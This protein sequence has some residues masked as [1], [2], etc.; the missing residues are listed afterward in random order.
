MQTKQNFY[1]C[2]TCGS[3]AQKPACERS[4]GDKTPDKATLGTW[5]CT[6]CGKHVKVKRSSEDVSK[7]VA[8]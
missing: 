2:A 3:Q 7:K 5:S 8:A 6:K 1:Y 4:R